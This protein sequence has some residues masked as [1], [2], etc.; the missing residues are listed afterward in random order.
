MVLLKKMFIW[1]SHL[2][3]K[4]ISSLK[5]FVSLIKPFYGLKQVPQAWYS[6]LSS[7]LQQIGFKSSKADTSL[8]IYH[9]KGVSI[10]LLIYV[11]DIIMASSN[12]AAADALLQEL[13]E[14]FALKDLGELSYFL[15]IEVNKVR[16][17]LLLTQG[18]YAS[19]LLEKA[20]MMNCKFVST[21]LS[22]SE[23]LSLEGGVLLGPEDS[24][25]YKSVVGGLQYLTLT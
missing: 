13:R 12:S 19:D 24:T 17:G 1:D 16:D 9:K 11:D 2:I 10:Y 14:E 8:F 4:I 18:K 22:T 5:Q 15:G 20:R 23:K 6:R 7:K 25:R 3:M 21:P